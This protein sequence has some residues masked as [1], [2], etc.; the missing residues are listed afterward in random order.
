[1]KIRRL[2]TGHTTEGNSTFV[3]DAELDAEV[4]ATR[5]GWAVAK[6]WAADA[7]ARFPDTGS[8][9]KWSTQFPPLGGYRFFIMTM[10]PQPG[11]GQPPIDRAAVHAEMDRVVPGLTDYF[12]PDTPGMHTSDTIDFG[13]VLSGRIWLEL[14][15]GES[16]ELRAGD[17]FIQNGTRHA[18]RN[19]SDAG[20]TV[21]F[22][23]VGAHRNPTG[24]ERAQAARAGA[25]R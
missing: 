4:L 8:E 9:P 7:P 5:P 17:C 20:C 21:L 13:Y 14:D 23:L 2:V 15:N 3:G 1:M 18:W 11:P 6:L 19:K 25:Q 24:L 22:V 16:R 10:V 12:E